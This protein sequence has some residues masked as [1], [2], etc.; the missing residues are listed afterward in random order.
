MNAEF[1]QAIVDAARLARLIEVLRERGAPKPDDPI[2]QQRADLEDGMARMPLAPGVSCREDSINDTPVEWVE[3]DGASGSRTMMYLHGGGYALGSL[4]TIR[5]LATHLAHR[6]GARVVT[7]DYRLAPE[8]P[9]PAALDDCV[10]VYRELIGTGLT[11]STLAIGGDSA[12]GGLAVAT[13][14]ALRDLALPLPAA[15]ICLSPWVDLTMAG[16]SLEINAP[17]DPLLQP[18]FLEALAAH[19]LAGE[20][21]ET[22]LASP[23]FADLRGLPPLL[24]QV[25]GAEILLDDARSLAAVAE[26]SGVDVT[27][28]CWADVM[29]VWHVFAPG[30]PQATRAIQRVAEWLNERWG[31]NEPAPLAGRPGEDYSLSRQSKNGG[32]SG[33]GSS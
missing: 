14:V 26:R 9:Y 25:S 21:P 11:P 30:L 6:L 19:Y 24:I 32:G 31:C 27:L 28:E 7:V 12:G 1:D 16:S 17:H 20:S 15:G 2:E 13:L 23:V 10:A 8:H 29:H 22:P 18:R 33:G 5:P 3:P 4:S